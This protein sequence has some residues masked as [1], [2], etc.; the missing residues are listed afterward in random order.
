MGIWSKIGK[1]GLMAA[2]YV[3]APFTGGAS[4]SFA[5]AASQAV[6]GW[7]A[8]DANKAAT[9]GLGPSKFDQYLGLAGDIGGMAGSMGAF[10]KMGG[11]NMSADKF[12]GGGDSDGGWQRQIGNIMERGGQIANTIGQIKNQNQA[13]KQ[14]QAS[15]FSQVGNQGRIPPTNYR[16]QPRAR[17][18]IDLSE[19]NLAYPIN[20]GRQMAR[21]DIRRRA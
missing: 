18:E 10:S 15:A 9:K 20:R 16:G 3:A 5:P 19:P 14:Q 7:N 17:Q 4:L 11:D 6:K 21:R 13:Q 1:I 2:P 12:G 8:R